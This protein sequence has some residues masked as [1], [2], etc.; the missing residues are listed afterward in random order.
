[1]PLSTDLSISCCLVI[2]FAAFFF[3]GSPALV[4][5]VAAGAVV[6]VAAGGVAAG[7]VVVVPVGGVWAGTMPAGKDTNRTAAAVRKSLCMENSKVAGPRNGASVIPWHRAS[8]RTFAPIRRP[9]RARAGLSIADPAARPALRS[10]PAAPRRN[11]RAVR[12]PTDRA[13][14]SR[15]GLLSCEAR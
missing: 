14:A 10:R 5:V 3:A 6:V 12:R 13:R 7:A 1:M 8:K 15:S 2:F 9:S 4:S 11:G